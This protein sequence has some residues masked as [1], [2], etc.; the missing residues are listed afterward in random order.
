MASPPTMPASTPS[1]SSCIRID[2]E[3][4]HA[5]SRGPL[6]H[7]VIP[8]CPSLLLRL[9]DALRA[10]EP[11]LTEVARI[12]GSDVAMSAALL[13]VANSALYRGDMPV[14]TIGQAMNRLGLEQTACEMRSYLVRRALPASNPR[15]TRFWER[16]AKRAHAM[17]FLARRLP[18][19]PPDVAHTCGLFSHVGLPV[20]LQSLPGYGG[21]MAEAAARVD[22]PYIATE[23]ANH[24][25]DHAVVGALVA[26]LW[27]LGATVVA[28]IRLHHEP[29]TLGEDP[30]DHDVARLVTM[31]TV[32]E[33]LMRRDEG[34]SPD[35]DWTRHGQRALDW[36][37]VDEEDLADWAEE[38]QS[39]FELA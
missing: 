9:Q 38:L 32:A 21:T 1:G 4:D 11:D 5:L 17:A 10:M 25:T 35:A 3:L 27:R 36:L 31:L 22:R 16:S 18:G 37:G 13:K 8:P 23:N 20:M 33:H 15:L 14:H 34:L 6:R 28:A 30:A 39:T 24:Q 19:I 7:I 12:V 26:R 2:H 29:D